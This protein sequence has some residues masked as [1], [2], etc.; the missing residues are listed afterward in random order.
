MTAMLRLQIPSVRLKEEIMR[1]SK[2]AFAGILVCS[3]TAASAQAVIDVE[4]LR[5]AQPP[6]QDQPATQPQRQVAPESTPQP[7]QSV[8]SPVQSAAGDPAAPA[9][10][11]RFTFNRIDDGYLRFDAQSGQV[12][13]CRVQA[14]GW[15]CEV[16]PEN[17]SGLEA[18][19]AGLQADI[20]DLKNLKT[21][22]SDIARL[23]DEIVLLRREIA[24][25]KEPPPPRPP[26]D[27]TP[28]DQGPDV[29]IRLPSHGDVARARAFLEKTWHRLVEMI[30]AVQ[31]DMMQRG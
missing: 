17:R 14:T 7:T 18:D 1:A 30:T 25:L 22:K 29:A 2:L 4:G 21:L 31:K 10:G 12:A 28:P 13:Y 3:A 15:T 26:A 9:G 24:T 11:G 8:E 16:V 20:K 5:A 6:V 23:Q 19:V 27:L